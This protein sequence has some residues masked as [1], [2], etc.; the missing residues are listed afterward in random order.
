MRRAWLAVGI[1]ACGLARAEPGQS[2][3]AGQAVL[4]NEGKPLKVPLACPTEDLDALGLSCPAEAPCEAFLELAAVE[5]VGARVFLIGNIHTPSVTLYSILLSSADAGKTWSE[6]HGRILNASLDQIQFLDYVNGWAGGQLLQPIPHDPFLLKSNDGGSTWR[7]YPVLSERRTGL[8]EWFRFETPMNGSLW[9]DRAQGAARE[10]RFERYE[11][12]TG[13]ESW[14]L[15][16]ATGKL[17]R[18][19]SDTASREATWRLR[20]DAAGNSYLLERSTDGQW[21]TVASFVIPVGE[22]K[23]PPGVLR[24]PPGEQDSGP[25]A[26]SPSDERKKR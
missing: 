8:I 18:E 11:T 6:A 19:G 21:R 15:S 16:Q 4:I 17:P 9:I 1:L 25:D 5:P 12:V 26:R 3:T 7:R 20:P 24:E 22:C 23:T 10:A 14:T 2:G 13:G